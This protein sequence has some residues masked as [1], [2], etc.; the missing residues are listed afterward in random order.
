[1]NAEIRHSA[2]LHAD[3]TGWRMSGVIHWLWRFPTETV[4][5]Y[6]VDRCRGSPA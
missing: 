2:V 5:M 3:E 6:L 4:T 1:M